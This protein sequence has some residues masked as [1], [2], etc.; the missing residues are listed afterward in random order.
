MLVKIQKTASCLIYILI[1]RQI[2][3]AKLE[4]LLLDYISCK[5][6]DKFCKSSMGSITSETTVEFARDCPPYATVMSSQPRYKI[7]KRS[8]R[9]SKT[10]Q[11]ELENW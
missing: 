2:R 10:A 7:E 4:Q 1:E 9:F 8:K 6:H 5:H 11:I 3:A